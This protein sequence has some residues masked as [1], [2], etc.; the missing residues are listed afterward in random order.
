MTK[1]KEEYIV[2]QGDTLWDIAEN[3]LNDATRWEEITRVNDG[4]NFT[5]KEAENLETGKKLCIPKDNDKESVNITHREFL[6][7]SNLTNLEW[8]FA[9]LVSEDKNGKKAYDKIVKLLSTPESFVKYN[10]ESNSYTYPYLENKT[11]KNITL[12][13]KET[14]KGLAQMRSKAGI[15]MEYLEKAEQDNAEASLIKDWEVIYGADNY[16][17]VKDFYDD[18]YEV[19]CKND[20]SLDPDDKPYDSRAKVEAA[21][22]A[23]ISFECISKGISIA[24]KIV[25]R[26]IE[27]KFADKTLNFKAFDDSDKALKELT[28]AATGKFLSTLKI[29]QLENGIENGIAM[30]DGS[31]KHWSL[32]LFNYPAKLIDK[33][34]KGK[35]KH[36]KA[37]L[38][39]GFDQ[40]AIKESNLYKNNQQ[41]DAGK[42]SFIKKLN[43]KDTGFRVAAFKNDNHEIVI[44]YQKKEDKTKKLL[45]EELDLLKLVHTKISFEH[46]DCNIRF[47]GYNN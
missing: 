24:S 17:I 33:V 31:R 38:E 19:M 39:Q 1:D 23:I 30:L 34:S 6:T 16:K 20:P 46:E 8:Q 28:E 45:P 27:F 36:Y 2:K 47:V 21:E 12:S 3:K 25:P 44:A 11:G 40:E 32:A 22:E 4:S 42:I 15:A 41:L 5:K 29:D 9:D 10:A 13:D 26:A 18:L 7:F 37:D 14:E 35:T 43:M